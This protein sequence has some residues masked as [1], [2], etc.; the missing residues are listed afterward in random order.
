MAGS[1]LRIQALGAATEVRA[2]SERLIADL[3]GLFRYFDLEERPADETVTNGF[4]AQIGESLECYRLVRHNEQILRTHSY[5]HLLAH[6]EFEIHA[7]LT[8]RAEG[9]FLIHAGAVALGECGFL[10]PG[11][12]GTGKTT[13]VACLVKHGFEFFTDD[14]AV[15]DLHT[16]RIVPHPRPLNIKGKTQQLLQ[17]LGTRLRIASYGNASEPYP[18]RYAM[19]CPDSIAKRPRP[20]RFVIF[21]QRQPGACVRLEPL[22]RSE[23]VLGLMHHALNLPRLPKE[24]FAL[25]ARMARHLESYRIVFGDLERASEAIHGLPFR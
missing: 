16:G 19:P 22:P 15:L 14:T 7:E 11:D 9:C 18:A 3:Q 17:P 13:L 25:A 2:D 24:E 5:P 8:R 4:Y 10:F 12:R 23:A 6:L 20:V 21:P 1:V